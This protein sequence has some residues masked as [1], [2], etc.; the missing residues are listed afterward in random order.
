MRKTV[1]GI[2]LHSFKLVR[3]RVACPPCRSAM[4]AEFNGENQ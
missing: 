3:A 1:V 4:L 2:D